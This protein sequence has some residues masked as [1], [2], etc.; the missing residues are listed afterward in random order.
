MLAHWAYNSYN[1]ES[2]HLSQPEFEL[3][4]IANDLK[5]FALFGSH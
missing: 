5:V 4:L 2:P 1:G 3:F